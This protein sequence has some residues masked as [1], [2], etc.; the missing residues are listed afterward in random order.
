MS[1]VSLAEAKAHLNIAEATHDAELQTVL[2]AAEAVIAKLVGPLT[3]TVVTEVVRSTSYAGLVLSTLPVVSLTSVTPNVGDA[4]V[5]GDLTLD[6]AAGLVTNAT[7]TRF[8]AQSY[9]VVYEAG[10]DPLPLDLQLAVKEL[11]RHLWASQRGSG[12]G[13]PGSRS[14]EALSNTLPGAAY[15]LPI[16]VTQMLDPYLLVSVA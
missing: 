5:V 1:V 9:T 11:L 14:A 6:G 10:Y 3:P 8:G 16:R 2:D 7:D 15:T 13:R 12:V 4:L